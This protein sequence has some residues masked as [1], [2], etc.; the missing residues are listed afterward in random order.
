MLLAWP[1]EISLTKMLYCVITYTGLQQ[2]GL[3]I[4]GWYMHFVL[5]TVSLYQY[6]CL[7]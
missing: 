3:L 2:V 7:A 4:E 5:G 6:H 1:A